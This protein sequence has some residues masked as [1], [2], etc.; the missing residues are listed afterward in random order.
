MWAMDTNYQFRSQ[1]DVSTSQPLPST[2]TS[3]SPVDAELEK[4]LS[5]KKARIKVIGIGD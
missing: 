3:T 5:K 4:I 1:S 2:G